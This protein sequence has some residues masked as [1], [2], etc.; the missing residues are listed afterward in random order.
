MPVGELLALEPDATEQFLNLRMGYTESAGHPDLRKTIA[1]IYQT[2]DADDVLVFA[3]AQ[4]AITLFLQGMLGP[5]DHAIV[6]W[7]CYQSLY[8]VAA[9]SAGAVDRWKADAD[10]GWSLD[11]DALVALIRPTTRLIII[12]TPHNPTGYLMPAADWL[13]LHRIAAA[14]GILVFCDEVYRESEYDPCDRLTAG[15]DMGDHAFSLGVMSKTYGLAGLRIGW[16]A[17]KNRD[18]LN[19][20]RSMKDYGSI[21]CSA[22]AEFLAD[23]GLRHR[24]H[25]IARN[26]GIIQENLELLDN[27][28]A[29]FSPRFQWHRPRAG[30]IAFP[31]L[32]GRDVEEFC[33][34][35]LQAAGV[36]FAPG[37]LFEDERNHFRIGFGRCS[38]AEGIESLRQYLRQSHRKP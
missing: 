29:E 15:C 28:F 2:V 22:P 19:R 31:G 32:N 25:L 11:L 12:N 5:D 38:M 7:P 27:F 10:N 6:H 16:V 8:A 18:G 26:V 34:E 30:A 17:T 33:D 20:L 35:V 1:G 13:E 3:G 4:E 23:L 37:T 14:R 36:L 21:C 24:Q 9:A